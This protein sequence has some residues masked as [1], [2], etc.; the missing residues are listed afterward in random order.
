MTQTIKFATFPFVHKGIHF[1]S[2][3][4]ETNRY[5]PQIMIMGEA[6]IEMNKKAID[7]LINLDKNNSLEVIQEILD[8]I[9]EGGTEMFLELGHETLK[10]GN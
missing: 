8:F 6:F 5:L 1:V 9:N 4:A 10:G 2:K 7:E 3:V